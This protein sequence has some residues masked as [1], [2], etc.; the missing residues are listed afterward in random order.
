MLKIYVIIFACF[1]TCYINGIIPQVSFCNLLLWLLLRIALLRCIHASSSSYSAFIFLFIASS[2]TVWLFQKVLVH[3]FIQR[4]LYFFFLFFFFPL[5]SNSVM[6]IFCTCEEKDIGV[7]TLDFKKWESSVILK[8]LSE[9]VLICFPWFLHILI[10]L[11]YCWTYR[12]LPVSYLWYG[13]SSF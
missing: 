9:I 11:S 13:I 7:E 8:L 6:D 10:I 4:C 3:L 2:I 1:K 12:F 5:S